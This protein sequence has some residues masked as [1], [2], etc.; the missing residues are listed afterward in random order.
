MVNNNIGNTKKFQD[1][2]NNDFEYHSEKSKNYYVSFKYPILTKFELQNT[3]QHC[4]K[5][6]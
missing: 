1:P 2:I 5:Q 6:L 3:C 4:F